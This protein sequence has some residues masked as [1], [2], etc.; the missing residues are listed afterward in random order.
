MPTLRHAKDLG[1][2][3][4]SNCKFD[5]YIDE[6]VKKAFQRSRLIL[7]TFLN[8]DQ[9][10]YMDMFLT[11]VRPVL[12]YNTPVWSPVAQGLTDKL[13]RVHRNYTW[14][15][16]MFRHHTFDMSYPQRLEHFK[17][18]SLEYRRL[19]F[20]LVQVFKMMNGMGALRPDGFFDTPDGRTRGHTK[21]LREKRGLRSS[22]SFRHG[23]STCHGFRP[24][25]GDIK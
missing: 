15:V 3:M 20:D 18:E 7:R 24:Y 21:R 11:K 16:A 10:F 6:I 12:E 17:L 9:K 13:E 1:I 2:I 22:P 19:K 8:R 14:R 4:Q 5:M 23:F 25:F